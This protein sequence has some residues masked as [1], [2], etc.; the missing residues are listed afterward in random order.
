M[1]RHLTGV[2]FVVLWISSGHFTGCTKAPYG[3]N[4]ETKAMKTK[5]TDSPQGESKSPPQWKIKSSPQWAVKS[6]KVHRSGNRSPAQVTS[7]EA[8]Y[9]F[10]IGGVRPY[11]MSFD[12]TAFVDSVS[13]HVWVG[14]KQ[15]FYIGTDSGI[16]GARLREGLMKWGENMADVRLAKKATLEEAIN[17]FHKEVTFMK[18]MD[19]PRGFAR[20]LKNADDRKN[21]EDHLTD[22]R[23]V[24]KFAGPFKHGLFDARD[25]EVKIVAVEVSG[26][27]VRLDLENVT[28]KRTGSAWIDIKTKKVTKATEDNEVT[29]P[30]KDTGP[31]NFNEETVP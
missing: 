23:H 3:T 17:R 7:K 15:D 29:F 30:R 2:A 21:Y 20:D 9:E 14:P 31:V 12:V 11:E 13:G 6:Q 24:F 27:E 10:E 19:N 25:A 5:L 1:R 4:G 8:V 16:V 28:D 26:G 22:V 18:L